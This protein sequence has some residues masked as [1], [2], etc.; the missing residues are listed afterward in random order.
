MESLNLIDQTFPRSWQNRRV[1]C[2]LR[3]ISGRRVTSASCPLCP[4]KRTQV[5]HRAMSAMCQ[6][7]TSAAVANDGVGRPEQRMRIIKQGRSAVI[8]VAAAVDHRYHCL[9]QRFRAADLRIG[10]LAAKQICHKL[11][12]RGRMDRPVRHQDRARAGIK[13]CAR[14]PRSRLGVP[15]FPRRLP[16]STPKPAA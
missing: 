10:G 7:R 3:V 6:Q 14:Q 16:P 4:P 15:R 1:S 5:G 11:A 13:E 2:P 9:A 12:R 8:L